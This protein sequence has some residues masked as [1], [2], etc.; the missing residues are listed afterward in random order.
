[1]VKVGFIVEGDTEKQIVSSESFKTLCHSKGIE[2]ISGVFPP[3]KKERGKDV[4]KN[5]E[6]LA[7]FAALLY[8]RGA[9]FIFCMRDLEDLSCI[10]SAKE[11]IK[12]TDEKV[13]KVI[14][15]KQIE[16]WFLGDITLLKT[17]FGEDYLELFPEATIPEMIPKPGE[18]LK[19][20]SI[21][22]RNGKGIGDKLLFAKSL[23]RNGFSIE[24][25]AQHCPSA[26]YFLNKLKHINQ[27][28]IPPEGASY[29]D[30]PPLGAGGLSL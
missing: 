25:S 4:F 13:K 24:H 2:V 27:A 11:E 22:T 21:R 28:P 1:M 5:V 23:I 15:V 14:V 9:D 10:T 3:N 12:S 20:I 17:Y 29:T 30:S 26:A 6:K 8:D 7:S 18:K 16:S 19:E